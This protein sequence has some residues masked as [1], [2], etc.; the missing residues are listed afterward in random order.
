[1]RPH[2]AR[3]VGALDAKRVAKSSEAGL[4]GES[5]GVAGIVQSNMPVEDVPERQG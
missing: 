1:M 4:I 2:P 5:L 3:N